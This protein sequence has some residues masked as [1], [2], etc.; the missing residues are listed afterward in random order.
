MTARSGSAQLREVALR[1]KATGQSGLKVE[2]TRA[3]RTGA[4]P[5]IPAVKNSAIEKLPKEGGLN[6][7]VAGQKI[8]VSIRTGPRTSGVRLT[9]TAP[10]TAQTNSG[11]VRHPVFGHRD[12]WV[13]Q[14]IP[15]ASGWWTDPLTAASPAITPVLIAVID[16]VSERINAV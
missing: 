13:T 4:A 9:T 11:F 3:L 5:L 1:L 12:R 2:M 7:Q 16:G 15:D 6:R 10:D 8:T 14:Q